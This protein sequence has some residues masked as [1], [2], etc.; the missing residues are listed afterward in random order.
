MDK[1]I[2][3]F[4]MDSACTVQEA[5]DFAVQRI[6]LKDSAGFGLFSV[7][8]HISKSSTSLSSSLFGWTNVLLMDRSEGNAT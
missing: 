7:Y 6:Q 4:F 5:F 2:L 1:T 3:E 8:S